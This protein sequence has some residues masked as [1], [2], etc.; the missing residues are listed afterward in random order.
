[1]KR[2]HKPNESKSSSRG[3]PSDEKPFC[4][5]SR[6]ALERIRESQDMNH[7]SAALAIYGAL[8][9]IASRKGNGSESFTETQR[10]I[11]QLAGIASRNTLRKYLDDLCEMQLVKITK[12]HYP[13]GV[14]APS[15]YT[16]LSVRGVCQPLTGDGQR[17]CA[18]K[19]EL[20]NK[21]HPSD[22]AR[23]KVKAVNSTRNNSLAGRGN[24]FN[25]ER[26]EYEW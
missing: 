2:S 20:N 26:G 7:L 9:E 19:R 4:W 15:T 23:K 14:I 1:V 18:T 6:A 13:N 22:V 16:L 3:K 8:T 24:G 11:M 12:N 17:H 10:S 21:V 5:Q 25:H